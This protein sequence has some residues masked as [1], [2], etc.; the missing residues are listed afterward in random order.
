MLNTF[1]Y[2][3]VAPNNLLTTL[4]GK[5]CCILAPR[6]IATKSANR[7]QWLPPNDTSLLATAHT[8]IS[9]AKWS[10]LCRAYCV[11]DRMLSVLSVVPHN[12]NMHAV[13]IGKIKTDLAI[14]LSRSSSNSLLGSR[15]QC[16]W[17]FSRLREVKNAGKGGKKKNWTE[18]HQIYLANFIHLPTSIFKNPENK[19]FWICKQNQKKNKQ[20]KFPKNIS[21]T[22]KRLLAYLVL[23]FNLFPTLTVQIQSQ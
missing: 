15:C 19:I 3:T 20:K 7:K 13:L 14:S 9:N 1:D 12:R 21:K 17:S 16:T 18:D 23:N 22:V 2:N 10:V 5:L 6:H 8:K 11:S 4:R